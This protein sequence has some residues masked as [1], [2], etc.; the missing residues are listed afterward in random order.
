MTRTAKW[1]NAGYTHIEQPVCERF[2]VQ[3]PHTKPPRIRESA[4][5]SV[6]VFA[7]FSRRNIA[8]RQK[9]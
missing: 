7:G 8:A 3:S 1:K 6:R 4:E 5:T 2:N 9:N